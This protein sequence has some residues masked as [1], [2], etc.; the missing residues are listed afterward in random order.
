LFL[1]LSLSL[2]S[3]LPSFLSFCHTGIWTQDLTLFSQCVTWATPPTLFVLVTFQI[4]PQV[5]AQACLDLDPPIYAFHLIRIIG[6][7]YH[8][9]LFI[10]KVVLLN[11]FFN[12]NHDPSETPPPK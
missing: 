11:F 5:L 6:I 10:E 2:S 3:F 12:L 8:A 7:H 9:G 1:S 4:G